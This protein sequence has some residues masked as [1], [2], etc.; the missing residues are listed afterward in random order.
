MNLLITLLQAEGE[1]EGGGAMTLVM[2]GA[3]IIIMYMFMLRPQIKK[4]KEA[5]KFRESLAV[6][7][8]IITAGG[9]H[10]KVLEINENTVLVSTEGAG[11]LRI[12]KNSVNLS[13]DS[14]LQTPAR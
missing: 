6:G 1:K 8:K 5:R 7:D 13:P 4:S 14:A 12:E 2:Y 10:G 9:I 11:K 3:I